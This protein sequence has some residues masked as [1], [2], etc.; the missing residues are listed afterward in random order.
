MSKRT[1]KPGVTLEGVPM[2]LMRSHADLLEALEHLI[3]LAQ[4]RIEDMGENA[5]GAAPHHEKEARRL[6]RL[7]SDRFGRALVKVSQ[8]KALRS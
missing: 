4:S 3:P 2:V 7:A 8:A 5:A 6:Y 1:K